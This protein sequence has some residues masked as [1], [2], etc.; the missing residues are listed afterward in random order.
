MTARNAMIARKAPGADTRAALV[1]RAR[2]LVATWPPLTDAQRDAL[3]SL[4]R[5][6]ASRRDAA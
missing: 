5:P 2:E 6:A 4:L 1:E 3:A